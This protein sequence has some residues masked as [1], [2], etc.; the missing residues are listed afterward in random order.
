VPT[1]RDPYEQSYRH[2]LAESPRWVQAIWRT[3]GRR[4]LMSLVWIALASWLV[5]PVI[6]DP[7]LLGTERRY[8]LGAVAAGGACLL[9]FTGQLIDSAIDLVRGRNS[10][11]VLHRFGHWLGDRMA[12]R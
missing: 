1:G 9:M 10:V 4:V 5:V 11:P 8:S 2:V 6:V 12:R 7:G 3:P